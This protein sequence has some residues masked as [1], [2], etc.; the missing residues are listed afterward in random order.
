MKKII[1]GLIITTVLGVLLFNQVYSDNP[2][3]RDKE[4]IQSLW[5]QFEQIYNNADGKL[6]ANLWL[7]NGDLFSLSGGVFRGKEEI[8]GFF[9]KAFSKNYKG[10]TF[11]MNINSIRNIKPDVAVVDGS[12]EVIGESLPKGY[13]TR[14][15]YTQ[16]LIK[17]NNEWK[18][19]LARPSVPLQGHTR[20]YG[21]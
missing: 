11:K 1:V 13:P 3:E 10:S 17:Q 20:N 7:E 15:I 18:I 6:L 12:W 21:R 9:V 16:V 5:K 2:I 8:E 19:L 4:K 14:G